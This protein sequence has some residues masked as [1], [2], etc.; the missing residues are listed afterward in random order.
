MVQGGGNA[1]TTFTR[2]FKSCKP[3]QWLR[4][5][6]GVQFARGGGGCG[7]MRQEASINPKPTTLIPETQTLNPEPDT[8]YPKP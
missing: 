3:K 6:G 2:V 7:A 5:R 1:G 8:R 4:E